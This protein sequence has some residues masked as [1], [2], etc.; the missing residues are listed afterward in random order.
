MVMELSQFSLQLI[1]NNSVIYYFLTASKQTSLIYQDGAT[2]QRHL[3]EVWI[4]FT[5][6]A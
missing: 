6:E 3:N 5:S 1:I 4:A 2:A